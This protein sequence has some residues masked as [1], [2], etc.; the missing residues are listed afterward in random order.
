MGATM[1]K[2]AEYVTLLLLLA[3]LAML[4]LV[5][6]TNAAHPQDGRKATPPWVLVINWH[7]GETQRFERREMRTLDECKDS[8][9]LTVG[10]LKRTRGVSDIEYTC[11]SVLQ[12]RA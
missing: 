1:N 9:Y 10:L 5:L 11:M 12:V 3:S 6:S 8:G 7:D 4:A 2:T